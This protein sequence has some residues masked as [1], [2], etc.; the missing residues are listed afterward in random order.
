[1]IGFSCLFQVASADTSIHAFPPSL[2]LCVIFPLV[3]AR[4]IVDRRRNISSNLSPNQRK[5]GR[6]EGEK[7]GIRLSISGEG[8][9]MIARSRSSIAVGLRGREGGRERTI[10]REGGT[11]GRLAQESP[12]SIFDPLTF[13]PTSHLY[14]FTLAYLT[15]LTT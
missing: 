5:K 10:G 8:D 6:E 13:V 12:F 11:D 9:G 3:V 1:M 14:I 2:V 15:V 4:I 7:E